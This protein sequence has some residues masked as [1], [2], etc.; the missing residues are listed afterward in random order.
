MQTMTDEQLAL[1]ELIRR[2]AREDFPA[3]IRAVWPEYEF[4]RTGYHQTLCNTLDGSAFACGVATFEKHYNL[5]AFMFYPFLKF[6]EFNLEAAE[7]G[8]IELFFQFTVLLVALVL[9]IS[10]HDTPPV[11]VLIYN[12]I[13]WS[14]GGCVNFQAL[15]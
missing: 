9:L 13:L 10:R 2:Q 3:F 8:F 5:Q 15:E 1:V 6:N 7:F 4:S 12:V 14:I 11:I